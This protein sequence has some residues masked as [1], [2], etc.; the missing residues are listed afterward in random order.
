MSRGCDVDEF[1]A[2]LSDQ[3][4][5]LHGE[6]AVG[7]AIAA[8]LK[9]EEAP[10]TSTVQPARAA[11][12]STR[13]VAPADDLA[14]V[15]ATV[16]PGSTIELAPGVYDVD[17]PIIIDVGL[18]I[19]G[20][21]PLSTIVQSSADS[22]GVVFLGGGAL[23][24]SG[25]TLQHIGDDPASVFMAVQG[26]LSITDARFVGGVSSAEEGGGH[27]LVLAF[28][29]VPG[30]P[31]RVVDDPS[32]PVR[33]VGTDF[34][35]N[36]AAGVLV[37]GDA[38][39]E[40]AYVTA[41]G[42][43]SCGICLSGAAGGSII[44]STSTGNRIGLQAGDN[45]GAQ[46]VGSAFTDNV[47]AGVSLDGASNVRVLDSTVTGNGPI[48]IQV[49]GSGAGEVRGTAIRDHGVGVLIT[50]TSSPQ[51]VGNTIDRHEIGVRVAVGASPQVRDNTIRRTSLAGVSVVDQAR[52]TVAGNTITDAS[53]MGVQ[54]IGA[55][56][57]LISGNLVDGAAQAG[58][59][60]GGT[61]AP[62]VTD[63][64]LRNTGVAGLLIAERASGSYT[65]N[66]IT[67]SRTVGAMVAGSASPTLRGNSLVGNGVGM[68][69]RENARATAVA[70]RIVDHAV[71]MQVVDTAS[72]VV[73]GN[74]IESTTEAGVAF[75]GTSRGRFAGNI[76][77]SNGNLSIQVAE[78]ARPD[79][80][81]NELR[82]RSVYGIL[83]R[84]N[85]GGTASGNRI[86]DHIFAIQLGNRAAPTL[87]GNVFRTIAL[88]SI[89]YADS[90]GGTASGN[91]C[92]ES[93]LSAG[94]SV[95]APA[96]PIIGDNSC[97]VT[98][99]G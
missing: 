98:R 94:I 52:G 57:P 10:D 47:D 93:V 43:G 58:V 80:V 26:P 14:E 86:V 12:A 4:D 61:A 85:A 77:S 16:G 24:I 55:A 73:E 19:V 39:P 59:Q 9:G 17:D 68:V 56:A 67:D 37:T 82:G 53:D 75:A 13:R 62:S 1:E 32:A 45:A 8:A 72:P 38:A 29:Q 36:D 18:T 74:T 5:G 79:I 40:L 6:G 81:G 88:T 41:S 84:D 97:T 15:L 51:V 21:G 65:G 89:V 76:L 60:V 2:L 3:I 22:V 91:D 7:E 50:G 30:F 66:T 69:F 71:G 96:N 27:G 11:T 23:N 48:G 49:A 63:N 28:E 92:E 42:N 25:L 99:S 54:V 20:A 35:D 44:S 90:S 70:N 78:F 33:V 31:D 34:V 64:V 83:Y 87:T 95:T 46:V